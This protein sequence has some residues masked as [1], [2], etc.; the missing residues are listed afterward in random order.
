[1]KIEAIEKQLGFAL[2]EQPDLVELMKHRCQN[3]FARDT[4]GNVIGLNLRTNNLNDDKIAFLQELPHLQAL[5]LSENNLSRV[6][7]P[8]EIK[9]LKYLNLSENESLQEVSFPT[10]GLPELEKLD[11][12]ECNLTALRI[13]RLARLQILYAQKNQLTTVDFD[14]YCPALTFLDLS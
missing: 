3:T 6:V 9:A 12:S 5:N 11:L 7:F 4:D 10:E 13:P 8:K 1:M 14:S 2:T